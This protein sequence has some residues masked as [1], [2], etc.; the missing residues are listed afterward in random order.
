[1]PGTETVMMTALAGAAAVFWI[2]ALGLSRKARRLAEEVDSSR[3]AAADL[4][5]KLR[6][7]EASR[8]QIE[9]ILQSMNEGVMVVAPSGDLLLVNDAARRILALNRTVGPGASFSESVRHPDLQELVRQVLRTQEPQVRELILYA[10]VESFLQIQASSCRSAPGD[11]CAL[12]VFHDVTH[13]KKLEQVRRDFVANVSHELKTPL[14]SIRAAAETLLD[15]AIKDADYSRA[16]LQTI[17]EE[18]DRLHRL[19]DDLLTLARVESR[20][21]ALNKERIPLRVFLEDQ[22]ARYRPLAKTHGVSLEMEPAP[23]TAILADRSQ[24]AQAVN[25]LLEN[26]IKYNRAGGRVIVRAGESA[27]HWAVEVED[28]G[29]GI[30]PEDLPRVFERFYRVDK[31]RSRETGGTGLGLSIVKHVAETHGGSVQVE[32]RPEH[33]TRFILRIPIA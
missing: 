8:S 22:V 4:Q 28:T 20:Q 26:A 16:F 19:V 13:F 6:E 10:P 11:P 5:T 3:R 23:E 32:S 2:R 25:N 33:G 12:V 27:G 15:G 24:L 9:A 18:T 31:A 1:M 14:T 30:P 7:L 29:I 21:T 17:S